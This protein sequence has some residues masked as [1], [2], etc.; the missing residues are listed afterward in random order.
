MNFSDWFTE[1]LVAIFAAFGIEKSSLKAAFYDNGLGSLWELLRDLYLDP[2]VMLLAIP[3]WLLLGHLRP[4]EKPTATAKASLLL[5]FLYPLFSLPIN[6]TI[7]IFSASAL[8]ALFDAHLPFMNT[9]LL[10]NQPLWLQA[11]GAFLIV[12]LMFYVTHY[13]KHK[14][15]WLW[16]FHTIHHSQRYLNAMTTFRNHP[17]EDLINLL[18]ASIPIAIIGGSYPAWALF[19]FINGM[20]G[21]Y[22]H[23]SMRFSLGPLNYIFITPQ[24]HRFH[25]T[26]NIEETDRNFG[27]RLA[28]WDWMFGTL[29]KGFSDYPETGVRGCEQLEEQSTNLVGLGRTFLRQFMYPFRAIA[30]DIKISLERALGRATSSTN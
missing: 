6:A 1:Q 7:V 4:A 19:V 13:L 22:I 3:L 23:S 15:R 2:Y 24:N 8:T 11:L 5:D 18:V 17:F 9:G 25:H 10:D 26:I 20:W 14:V 28:I 12:D 27:E 21:F 16:Y 29:H 30:A